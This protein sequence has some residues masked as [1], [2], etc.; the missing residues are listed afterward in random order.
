MES[1]RVEIVLILKLFFHLM[2]VQ[3][4]RKGI[5]QFKL[6][7]VTRPIDAARSETLSIEA[8]KR[9]LAADRKLIVFFIGI[10]EQNT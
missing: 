4:A 6:S 5:I 8:M 7:S 1:V 9:I 2:Q 3:T 10:C